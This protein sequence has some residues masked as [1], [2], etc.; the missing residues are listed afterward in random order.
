MEITVK[1]KNRSELFSERPS[2]RS[3]KFE[4]K[5]GNLSSFPWSKIAK[6]NGDI[7]LIPISS[8][9]ELIKNKRRMN[10][11]LKRSLDDMNNTL[12]K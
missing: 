7:K 11:S 6:M 1:P 12:L 4:K 5:D 10:G 3:K 2:H 8:T 9:I